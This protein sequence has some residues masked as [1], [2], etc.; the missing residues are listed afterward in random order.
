[1]PAFLANDILRLWRT[2]CLNYEARTRRDPPEQNAKRRLKNYKLK[3]S[4]LLTCFS[5]LAYLLAVYCREGTVSPGEVTDMVKLSPTE[6]LMK[7]ERASGDEHI[8]QRVTAVLECYE[9]FLRHTNRKE[10]E[11]LA[12]FMDS[13]PS[14]EAILGERV[15]ELLSAIGKDSRFYRVLVV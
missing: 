1:M 13:N 15:Y 14:R 11:L 2:F 3:H 7:L 9:E 4:R 6:R 5:A 12:D 10:A 8:K